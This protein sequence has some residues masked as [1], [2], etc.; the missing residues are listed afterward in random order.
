MIFFMTHFL[1]EIDRFATM[2]LATGV[3]DD[4]LFSFNA[5]VRL[6]VDISLLLDAVCLIL[7]SCE[8]HFFVYY[9]LDM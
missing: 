3:I 1:L 8:N 5:N 4:L 6:F 9:M 7:L 2:F